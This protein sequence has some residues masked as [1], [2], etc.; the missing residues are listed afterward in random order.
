MF[1]RYV[2]LSP[3]GFAVTRE[4]PALNTVIR[5]DIAF[6]FPSG[7]QDY[8]FREL[9]NLEPLMIKQSEEMFRNLY[10]HYTTRERLD[11]RTACG[12]VAGAAISMQKL[13]KGSM[14]RM[15]TR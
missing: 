12:L 6:R 15:T 1:T 11:H 5:S 14:D 13:T 10:S 2:K 7:Q 8:L 9:M 4:A 3:C